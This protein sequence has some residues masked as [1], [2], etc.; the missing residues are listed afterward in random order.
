MY[1]MA[2]ITLMEFDLNIERL[3]IYD[4]ISSKVVQIYDIRK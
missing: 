1:W 3:V 4:V 2:L